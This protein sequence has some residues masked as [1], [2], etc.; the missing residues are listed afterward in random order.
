ME[1]E[2]GGKEEKVQIDLAAFED[3]EEPLGDTGGEVN[4]SEDEVDV[5][6]EKLKLS[7]GLEE[8]IDGILKL[9][10]KGLSALAKQRGILSEVQQK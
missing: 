9:T 3:E 8:I 5:D 10:V 7:G 2:V 6:L 1:A 4:S